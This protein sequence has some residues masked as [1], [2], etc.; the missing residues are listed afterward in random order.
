[1]TTRG[2]AL[3]PPPK[4]KRR[5]HPLP[6]MTQRSSGSSPTA[7]C[8]YSVAFVDADI[9]ACHEAMGSPV[10]DESGAGV[11]ITLHGVVGDSGMGSPR[12]FLGLQ[13]ASRERLVASPYS[14]AP[15]GLSKPRDCSRR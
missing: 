11:A 7:E 5:P 10:P 12:Y 1:M 8:V 4:P 6:A 3:R 2:A 9:L 15:V 14:R 13:G